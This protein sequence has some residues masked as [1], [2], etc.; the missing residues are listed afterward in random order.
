MAADGVPV[1]PWPPD[2]PGT[3]LVDAVKF[4]SDLSHC[5]ARIQ[6]EFQGLVQRLNM[7]R[8]NHGYARL[9]VS[10]PSPVD[11][12]MAAAMQ[13]MS[14]RLQEAMAEFKGLAERANRITGVLRVPDLLLE[15]SVIP[16][17]PEADKA[18]L[19]ALRQEEID[20]SAD[21]GSAPWEK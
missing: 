6:G 7:S 13:E 4:V 18:A 10:R 16:T 20:G 11:R 12:Q 8:R 1:G 9:R 2:P 19:I 14:G 21:W 5:L 15:M 3:E 17:D